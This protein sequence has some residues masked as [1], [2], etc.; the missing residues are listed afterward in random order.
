[1]AR[2]ENGNIIGSIGAITF[3]TMNNKT[4]ARSK[5]A[6][7]VKKA[8]AKP[9]S[10]V[11]LF[12]LASTYG[13]AILNSLKPQLRFTFKLA[14]YNKFRS[15]LTKEMAMHEDNGDWEFSAE[16]INFC[17]L[18]GQADMRD[19][20]LLMPTVTVTDEGNI[21][22][23]FPSFIPANKIKAPAGTQ[24]VNVKVLTVFSPFSGNNKNCTVICNNYAV[25]FNKKATDAKEMIVEANSKKGCMV[26]LVL[27]VECITSKTS[28]NNYHAEEKYLPA[29]VMA[30][31]K[32]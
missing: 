23:S 16:Q 22:I 31:G 27:A 1:M 14:T 25:D 7:R 20:L 11:T 24:K 19:M 30:A 10:Q 29:A 28:D 2:V 4:Y 9:S 13:T 18:N 21:T 3:Y 6:K 32:L 12:S 17:N 8:N 26:F 5:Q 15:W